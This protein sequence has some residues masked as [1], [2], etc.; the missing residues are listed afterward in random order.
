MMQR[1]R[2]RI[3]VHAPEFLEHELGLCARIDEN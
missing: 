2:Q 1:D 3:V